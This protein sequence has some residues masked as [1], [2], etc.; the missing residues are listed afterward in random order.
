MVRRVSVVEKQVA[1]DSAFNVS[2]V[3]EH[4]KGN[5]PEEGKI[6]SG[7][8]MPMPR[9]ISAFCIANVRISLTSSTNTEYLR[10]RLA[11]FGALS[12]VLGTSLLKKVFLSG[13]IHD[14]SIRSVL[15][16]TGS[17]VSLQ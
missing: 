6:T 7:A 12:T 4:C 15:L 11:L 8:V 10:H 9:T 3:I 5:I 13:V 17:N 1:R 14:L 16:C 2:K